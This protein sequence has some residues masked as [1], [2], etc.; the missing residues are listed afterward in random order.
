MN[1]IKVF[2]PATVANVSCGYDAMGFAL[3]TLGDDMIFTKTNSKDV[4][5]SKIEGANLP[6]EANK[7]VAGVVA[8]WMVELVF[9]YNFQYNRSHCCH[10]SCC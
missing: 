6:Y 2:S 9:D 3:E 7:N 10:Y 5:I 1:Q 4:V 8:Q